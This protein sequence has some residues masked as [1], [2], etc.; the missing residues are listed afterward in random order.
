MS[1]LDTR[2]APTQ[3]ERSGSTH[4]HCYCL[5]CFS[6][7]A[8]CGHWSNTPIDPFA[9]SRLPRCVVC[10]DLQLAPCPTCGSDPFGASR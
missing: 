4:A 10:V 8:M 1:D 2:P 3:S 6:R 9:V 7:R 5:E